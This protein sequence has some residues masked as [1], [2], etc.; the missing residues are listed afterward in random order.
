ME[1]LVRLIVEIVQYIWPFREVQHWERG[2]YMVMGRARWTVGHG[3]WPV[4]PYFMDVIAVTTVPAMISTPLQTITL[5]NGQTLTYSAS[6]MVVVEDARAALIRIDS[7]QQTTQE[8]LAAHLAS[9]MATV[10]VARMDAER[11]GRLLSS[12]VKA[13]DKETSAYGVRCTGLMFTNFAVNLRAYRLLMDSSV[14]MG[15]QG[16]W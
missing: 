11:R 2:V 4:V 14:I 10:D 13:L 5:A 15:T 8:L 3:R 7:Y 1:G 12:L 6:A 16:V 9:E